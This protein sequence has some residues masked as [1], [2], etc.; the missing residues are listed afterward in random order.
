MRRRRSWSVR[1]SDGGVGK[2]MGVTLVWRSF[3]AAV[4]ERRA[5]VAGFE[6]PLAGGAV[7]ELRDERDVWIRLRC[8]DKVKPSGAGKVGVT[9][10]S[11]WNRP[12]QPTGG[13]HTV[14]RLLEG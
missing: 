2:G 13:R 11:C 3:A 5:W 7:P 6:R 14:D 9:Y 1:Q 10:E 4:A 8:G 12:E